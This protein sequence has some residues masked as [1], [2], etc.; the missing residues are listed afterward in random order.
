MARISAGIPS[1]LN[2]LSTPDSTATKWNRSIFLQRPDAGKNI[3]QSLALSMSRRRDPIIRESVKQAAPGVLDTS[4]KFKPS[5]ITSTNHE[6]AESKPDLNISIRK[7]Y[8]NFL[9]QKKSDGKKENH[10]VLTITLD[11]QILKLRA[12]DKL[13]SKGNPPIFNGRLK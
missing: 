8:R 5:S 4:I 7:S 9:Q 12:G 10:E 13:S 2:P 11:K 1:Q 6:I 3:S